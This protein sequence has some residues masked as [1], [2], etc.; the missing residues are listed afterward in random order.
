[1]LDRYAR[2]DRYL[3]IATSGGYRDADG[4]AGAPGAGG[5]HACKIRT[6][7]DGARDPRLGCARGHRGSRHPVPLCGV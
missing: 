5:A 1:M 7:R 2:F 4:D 3:F 6:A